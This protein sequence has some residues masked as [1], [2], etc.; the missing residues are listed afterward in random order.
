MIEPIRSHSWDFALGA[1]DYV[2]NRTNEVPQF[3]GDQHVI[4]DLERGT[5]RAVKFVAKDYRGFLEE[6]RQELRSLPAFQA[7]VRALADNSEIKV[8]FCLG[9]GETQLQQDLFIHYLEPLVSNA[10]RNE[11]QG[12]SRDGSVNALIDSLD[13]FVASPTFTLRVSVPLW[14]VRTDVS[15]FDLGTGLYIRQLSREQIDRYVAESYSWLSGLT[16]ISS[17]G[18]FRVELEGTQQAPRYGLQ[19]LPPMPSAE[20]RVVHRFMDRL[21]YRCDYLVKILRLLKPGT[22]TEAF[23]QF[24]FEGFCGPVL[25]T[26][27]GF[28]APMQGS[29]FHLLPEDEEQIRTL[30]PNFPRLH[31]EAR[32]A[33][34]MRRFEDSYEKGVIEDRLIDFWIALESLFVPDGDAGELTLRAAIRL[35]HFLDTS[36]SEGELFTRVKQSYRARSKIVHGKES[37][38]EP[39][40]VSETEEWVRQA[41]RRFL[42]AGRVADDEALR[43]LLLGRV[44]GI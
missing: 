2:R 16:G 8:A 38:V 34:A 25:W 39:G 7:L 12:Q 15:E 1:I 9:E 19:L 44:D 4:D 37:S 27:T 41:L 43:A 20:G 17:V 10:L 13:A 11:D 5:L 29:A 31:R 30:L 33:L 24:S 21:S 23:V 3:S 28:K 22:V 14:N 42:A 26:T 35:T 18:L 40:L 6:R 36:H 32:F